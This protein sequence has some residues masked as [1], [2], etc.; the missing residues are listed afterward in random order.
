MYTFAGEDAITQ[1]IY[2][3]VDNAVKFSPEGGKLGLQVF[4]RGKKVCIAVE[5]DGTIPEEELPLIFDRF[6]KTDKSRSRKTEG[7]GLG[8][9]ITRQLLVRHGEDIVAASREGKTRFSFT[10]PLVK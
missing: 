7:W 5:N 9:Y 6:H 2:N 8:L 3:L 4:T 10:L 1:V